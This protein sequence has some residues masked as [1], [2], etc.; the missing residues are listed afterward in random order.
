MRR[1][2]A[3]YAELVAATDEYEER[4]VRLRQHPS[5]AARWLVR[6]VTGRGEARDVAARRD[7]VDRPSIARRERRQLHTR[8]DAD[9]SRA[10]VDA[11][12][13]AVAIHVCERAGF[14]IEREHARW[15]RGFRCGRPDETIELRVPK[16]TYA[17]AATRNAQHDGVGAG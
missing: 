10:Q 15:R 9:R 6:P 5:R 13:N 12:G 14:G 1:T 8:C 11:A 2:N 7:A 16:S 4:A 17:P 3:Q